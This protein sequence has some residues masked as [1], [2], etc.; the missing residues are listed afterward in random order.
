[1]YQYNGEGPKQKE[2]PKLHLRP[3]SMDTVNAGWGRTEVEYVIE[4]KAPSVGR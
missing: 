4:V 2:K 3:K 1:M